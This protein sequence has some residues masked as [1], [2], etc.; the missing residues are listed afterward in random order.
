MRLRLRRTTMAL[1]VALLISVFAVVPAYANVGTLT[2][3]EGQVIEVSNYLSYEI[4]DGDRDLFFVEAPSEIAFTGKDYG[5]QKIV[6]YPDIT[7]TTESK[8]IYGEP[9]PVPFAKQ[10]YVLFKLED[11]SRVYVDQ[12]PENYEQTYYKEYE[13]AEGNYAVLKK[14]GMYELFFSSDKDSKV[15]SILIEVA[16]QDESPQP[17]YPEDDTM[18]SSKESPSVGDKPSQIEAADAVPTS[19]KVLVNGKEVSFE[20]Y[21]ISGNNFFKLRDLAQ[22][23]NGSKKQFEVGWDQEHNAISLESE[24]AYTAVGGELEVS[25]KPATQQALLTGSKLYLDGAALDLTAY[26]INGN[27]YFKLRDIAKAFNIGVTWDGTTNTVGI[28]AALDYVEN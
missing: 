20:A 22:A 13:M 10:R 25:S 23:V 11:Q 26:N 9:Q 7:Y 28:D 12:I 4:V 18:E 14:S 17:A 27:N 15:N 16:I 19:S 3:D 24:K 21:N 8:F 1:A 2:L 6:Y 5:Y